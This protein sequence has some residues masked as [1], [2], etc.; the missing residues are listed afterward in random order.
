MQFTIDPDL[1][2]R[3]LKIQFTSTAATRL[4]RARLASPLF[5]RAGGVVRSE[6]SAVPLTSL[7][8]SLTNRV[9][10]LNL[11]ELPP[12]ARALL[13]VS[14]LVIYDQSLRDLSRAQVLA[15]DDWLAAGGRMVIIGSLNF[16]LYQEPQLARYLPVRV[17]GVKR[18]AF[19]PHGEAGKG[20]AI[21][22]VWAQTATVAQRQSR[23]RVSRACRCSSKTTG[24]RARS[25][26]SRWTRAGRHCRP[27]AACRSFCKVC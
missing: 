13:G 7:G 14:H 22:G 1:L 25:F 27:G 11:A 9:V 10:A 15:L 2:S 8:A 5:A 17:T 6:G 24:A 20:E 26:T 3:P 16:T 19:A 23:G 21:A 12:E 4:T 18:T